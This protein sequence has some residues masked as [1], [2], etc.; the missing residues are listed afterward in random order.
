[1]N[2]LTIIDYQGK[3]AI[4]S[5]QVA[6]MVEKNHADL[7]RSIKGYVV[8]LTESNF[9]VSEFFIESTYQDSTGRTLPCYMITRKGCD[10]V[11]NK[12][13]G[14]KGVLFTA[15]YVTKFDEMGKQ[16]SVS[17]ETLSIQSKAK[18]AEARLLNAKR[19]DAEFLLMV[20]KQHGTLS[21][22]SRELLTIN[23]VERLTGEGFLPRPKVDKL[24]TATEIGKEL[25][26]SS[27][28]VGRIA[29]ANN[30]KTSDYGLLVLDKSKHSVKQVDTFMYREAG[31]EEI[32]RLFKK[33]N[34]S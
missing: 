17:S 9:A 12:M 33:M 10:M 34:V 20:A 2:D 19:K 8:I 21:P 25:G 1:M 22:E 23:A 16:I 3:K 29:N 18:N 14:E 27:N 31:K 6:E 7:L 11:A 28:M 32:I 13:T 15:T 4:D 30:L 5:R 26:I 24:Y